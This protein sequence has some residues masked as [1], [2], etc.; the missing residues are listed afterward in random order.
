MPNFPIRRAVYYE[1]YTPVD[2]DHYVYFQVCAAWPK[3]PLG[4]ISHFLRYYLWGRPTGMVRFNSQDVAMVRDS[5][6]YEKRHGGNWPTAL[7]RPDLF[8]LAWR[9]MCN[10]RARGEAVEPPRPAREA[11]A[12][13]AGSGSDSPG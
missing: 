13:G 10:E 5:T 4:R 7:F 1:W 8:Q 12:S 6:D 3:G 2:E 11:A 9:T